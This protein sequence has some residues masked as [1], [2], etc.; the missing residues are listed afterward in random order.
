[1]T[2]EYANPLGIEDK[3]AFEIVI[4]N[5]DPNKVSIRK[6]IIIGGA[7]YISECIDMKKEDLNKMIANYISNQIN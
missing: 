2:Q 3:P 4:N 1:M 5:Y 7:T 6:T